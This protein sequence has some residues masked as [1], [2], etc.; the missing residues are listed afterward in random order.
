ML[1]H[2][3]TETT[4]TKKP[5]TKK[6]DLFG[7][8]EGEEEDDGDLFKEKPPPRESVEAPPKK[9]VCTGNFSEF[10]SILASINPECSEVRRS[11]SVLYCMLFLC[12]TTLFHRIK[13][14]L[15]KTLCG[16]IDDVDLWG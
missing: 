4:K 2:L 5:S 9:K 6:V 3:K 11:S 7:D 14:M 13:F 16:N 10:L 12:T 1:N 8:D 15:I